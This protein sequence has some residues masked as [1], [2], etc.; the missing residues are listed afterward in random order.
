MIKKKKV[1]QQP[2]S[3]C[4]ALDVEDLLQTKVSGGMNI[5]GEGEGEGENGEADI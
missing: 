3:E 4:I 2:L 5:G 1:Y